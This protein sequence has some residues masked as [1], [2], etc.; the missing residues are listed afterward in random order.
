MNQRKEK[1]NRE[2]QGTLLSPITLHMFQ[3]CE[4]NWNNCCLNKVQRKQ[5]CYCPSTTLLRESERET[6][7][8][9]SKGG[10]AEKRGELEDEE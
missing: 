1:T 5:L 4:G 9:G 8:E 3:E 10:G 2:R 7:R 6:E